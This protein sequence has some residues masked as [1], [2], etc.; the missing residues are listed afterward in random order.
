MNFKQSAI[1]IC[2]VL[3]LF[4]CVGGLDKP[5]PDEYELWMKQG[6]SVLE[7][8]QALLECGNPSPYSISMSSATPDEFAKRDRCMELAGFSYIGR[9][10]TYCKNSSKLASCQP[11]AVIPK[12]DPQRRFDSQFCK[13][14]TQSDICKP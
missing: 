4:A 6:I 7:I 5:P 1:L 11:E 3:P 8:K 2:C 14:Y 10:G 13:N 12:R 9:L